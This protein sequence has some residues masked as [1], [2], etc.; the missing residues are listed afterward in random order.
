MVAGQYS[1]TIKELPEEER[2]REKLL[3]SGSSS[4]SNAELLALVIRTGTR[5]RTAV[6]L[7]Q[8][9]LNYFG[10]L[11]SLVN[12]SVEEIEKIKGVG[13]AKGTRINAVIELSKRLY[14]ATMEESVIIENPDDVAKLV[15]PELR[16][17]K[18]EVFKLILLDTKNE[19]IAMPVITKGGLTSSIVHPREVFK[20]AIRRSSA[21]IILVHNH[22]SGL[23]DPSG[24]DIKITRRLIEA[25]KIMGVE[26]LDHLVI[27]DGIYT[28][29]KEKEII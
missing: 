22:P 27:G 7:A 11:K 4:L 24:E 8:D 9:I 19:V 17:M 29:M 1:Y 16:Y 14:R 6:E 3:K 21:S 12:L 23:P 15:M 26:V 5:E 10:G 20:E 13:P 2:P 28:S 18:Q 25:G